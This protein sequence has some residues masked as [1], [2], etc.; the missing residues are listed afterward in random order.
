MWHQGEETDV[1]L[2]LSEPDSCT[3]VWLHGRGLT[4]AMG[5]GGV[6]D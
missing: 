1:P 3:A 4:E 5:E 6:S 2:W